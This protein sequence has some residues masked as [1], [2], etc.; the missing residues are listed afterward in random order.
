MNTEEVLATLLVGGLVGLFL[1]VGVTVRVRRWSP[2]RP[3]VDDRYHPAPEPPRPISPLRTA[4]KAIHTADQLYDLVL[5]VIVIAMMT[6]GAIVAPRLRL[7]LLV[8]VVTAAVLWWGWQG[9]QKWLAS[10]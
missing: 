4:E 5:C 2:S 10:R 1:F 8:A 7:I 6:Y 3:V 9:L